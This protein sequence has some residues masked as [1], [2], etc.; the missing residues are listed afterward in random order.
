MTIT[1]V[2]L[3]VMKKVEALIIAHKVKVTTITIIIIAEDPLTKIN[4]NTI[5]LLQVM[6]TEEITTL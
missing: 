2:M 3:I 4:N 1:E 5:H 6:K